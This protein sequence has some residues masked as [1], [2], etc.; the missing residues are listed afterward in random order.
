[1]HILYDVAVLL[2]APLEL[3][4]DTQKSLAMVTLN[5]GRRR[6]KFFVPQIVFL[7][8][9]HEFRYT[10]FSSFSFFFFSVKLSLAVSEFTSPHVISKYF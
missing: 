7:I 6:N 9:Q 5:V 10:G 8:L 2:L 4:R 3:L 1:M